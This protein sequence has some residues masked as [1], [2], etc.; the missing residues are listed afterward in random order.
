MS[1]SRP[2]E[3]AEHERREA[4]RRTRRRALRRGRTGEWLAAMALRLKGYRIVGRNYRTPL[5]EIDIVARKR[6]LI[7]F[8]EVK[9][10][11]SAGEAIDAVGFKAQRR[12]ANAAEIWIARQ[13]DHHLLSWRF[14]IVAVVPRRWPVHFEDAF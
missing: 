9:A 5:G 14:D 8:V 2:P 13:R 12:I 4:A 11:A 1:A 7:V 6:D 3:P 10:R